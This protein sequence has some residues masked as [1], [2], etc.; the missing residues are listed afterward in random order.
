MRQS[1]YD[2]ESTEKERR[3]HASDS[4]PPSPT[5]SL[6]NHLSSAE[7]DIEATNL[8]NQLSDNSQRQNATIEPNGEEKSTLKSQSTRQSSE[9]QKHNLNGPSDAPGRAK[10]PNAFKMKS[11]IMNGT[12]YAVVR[13]AMPGMPVSG[14]MWLSVAMGN[15]KVFG[16]ILSS[17]SDPVLIVSAPLSPFLVTIVPS[18]SKPSDK[19]YVAALTGRTL[20]HDALANDRIR[21]SLKLSKHDAYNNRCV[22]VFTPTSS[23]PHVWE[24][25]DG[26]QFSVDLRHT[27]RSFCER[28]GHPSLST[29]EQLVEGMSIFP[30][31]D[32][33]GQF[34][35]WAEWNTV[36]KRLND[37]LD[38]AS[39]PSDMRLVV[40]GGSGSGKST[41]TRCI[42]NHLLMRFPQVVLID[43]DVG[44]SEMS[45]PGLVAAYCL[46][47]VRVGASAASNRTVPLS[48]R[49]FGD[50]TPREEPDQYAAFVET[51]CEEAL[52]FALQH[53]CPVVVNSDGWTNGIGADLLRHLVAQV[54]SSHIAH[55]RLTG[56]ELRP[57]IAQLV[58]NLP[59]ERNLALTSPR[60][61]RDLNFHPMLLRELH[62]AAYF[63]KELALGRVY[64]VSLS[65]VELI[66]ANQNYPSV[67]PAE[68][69]NASLVAIGRRVDSRE[70]ERLDWAIQ[71]FGIIRGLDPEKGILY[72]C[73]PLNEDVLE[74]CEGLFCS[75]GI[76]VPQAL[77]FATA[78]QTFLKS[79]K[80]PY[81][82]AGSVQTAEA[83]RSRGTLARK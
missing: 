48:A 71:G 19:H 49:F 68:A 50:T 63:S 3:S 26:F 15:A 27:L 34:E 60:S 83:M 66:C 42:T 56:H 10:P 47:E 46:N 72:V 67:I 23:D 5:E 12:Q 77:F 74:Q 36:C 2:S 58:S 20:H 80:A 37:F 52:S 18:R 54:G 30:N 51:V 32:K 24:H 21:K 7:D 44:Q 14:A 70:S 64:N 73:S 4:P 35:E 17:Q 28:S 69:L 31:A 38:H 61:D 82:L 25:S 45:P 8:P 81:V 9:K 79:G 57:A 78:G 39:N 55:L 6:S 33:F 40:C 22:L 76:Q 62:I 41:F 65:D 53:G 13:L 43:S 16:Q 59:R 1:P 75:G 29:G 11:G